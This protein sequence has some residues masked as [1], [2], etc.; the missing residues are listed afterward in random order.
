MIILD[1]NI[2]SE[3]IQPAPNPVIRRWLSFNLQADF[4]TTTVTLAE[5]HRGIERLAEGRKR[6][7]LERG[8]KASLQRGL[9]ILEFDEAAA[10][11]YGAIAAERERAGSTH[12]MPD[13]M[14]A[15]I[16]AVSGATLATRNVKD[17]EGCGIEVVNPFAAA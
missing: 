8:L 7:V 3:L 17:F 13:L 4:S 5:I 10:G 6:Q 9:W 12:Q 11:T 1:T 14:I 16:T 15:A 2:F